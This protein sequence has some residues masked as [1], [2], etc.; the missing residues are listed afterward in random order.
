MLWGYSTMV[1]TLTVVVKSMEEADLASGRM[2]KVDVKNIGNMKE[3]EYEARY[4]LLV[5]RPRDL[6]HTLPVAADF[7]LWRL[8]KGVLWYL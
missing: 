2:T 6:S 7:D 3:A 5:M 1:E 8:E 4:L